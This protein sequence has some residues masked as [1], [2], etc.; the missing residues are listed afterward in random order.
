M[1][2]LETIPE[3]V[4]QLIGP[5]QIV[6]DPPG[7]ARVGADASPDELTAQLDELSLI[8][9]VF[10]AFRDGRGFSL[11]SVLRERGYAG[12]LRAAG[13]LIADHA[14]LLARSGY[15]GVEM[16][17]DAEVEEWLTALGSFSAVYQ[18]AADHRETVWTA[19]Q[20]A[21]E[22]VREQ[23][24]EQAPVRDPSER[25]ARLNAALRHASAEEALMVSLDQFEGRIAALSSFGAE[26]AVTLHM[27]SRIDPALPVL[28]LDTGKH[29]APTLEYRDRLIAQLGLTDVRVLKPQEARRQDPAGSLW[30]SD[31]DLCCHI[32][33][34]EPL[35]T[36]A[37]DFDAMITGRKRLHGG[38]RLNLPVF[39]NVGQQVRI[40]PLANWA[41][42]EIDAYF[43]RHGLER[44]PL[45]AGGYSSIGCWPCTQPASARGHDR[46]DGR[47]SGLAKTECGIHLPVQSTPSFDICRASQV[48]IA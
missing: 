47:W 31:P 21:R 25:V 2:P 28:F 44:H 16:P 43:D 22:Q 32:R 40:N 35:A 12:E 11:G 10:A 5:D 38:G 33:K 1:K 18:P 48:P 45:V 37:S 41:A 26:A 9:V 4:F 24:S 7:S 6:A 36:V 8:T 3:T 17:A 34:V 13:D 42:E 15:N 20:R 19:R 39:E 29:F 23:A 30:R 27:I 46:R 14:P